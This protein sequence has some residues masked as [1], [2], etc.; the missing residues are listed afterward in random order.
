MRGKKRKPTGHPDSHDVE[1][2]IRG[3]RD[4]FRAGRFRKGER[5]KQPLLVKLA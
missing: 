3:R 1:S 2:A 4:I 5:M